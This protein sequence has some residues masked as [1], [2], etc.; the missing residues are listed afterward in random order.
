MNTLDFLALLRRAGAVASPR[1]NRGRVA[2]LWRGVSLADASDRLGQARR[3]D[4]AVTVAQPLRMPG[5]TQRVWTYGDIRRFVAAASAGL[6]QRGVAVGD[7]V[8]VCTSNGLDMPLYCLGVSRAGGVAIP[9]N[10]KLSADELQYILDDSGARACVIDARVHSRVVQPCAER[11]E[12][13]AF[14]LA[15][16]AGSCELTGPSLWDTMS[17]AR[18]IEA[19][20][21]EL[22]AVA[23]IFY[24]SGTTGFPKGAM[25]TG[26]SLLSRFVPLLTRPVFQPETLLCA[27]PM[28]HIMGFVTLLACL[29]AGT[30]I[31]YLSRFH[32]EEVT[33]WL[34]SGEVDA[35]LGVPS[36]YQMLREAGA[37]ERDL[38]GVKVFASAA[39]VMP[40]ELIESFKAAGRLLR[41]PRG[42]GVP[43]M[44]V[45]AYGS[46]ELSGAAMLRV[47]PPFLSPS[48]GGFVGWP[49]PGYSIRI[50]GDDGTELPAGE[51]G[52]LMI[53]GPGVLQG[54]HGRDEATADTIRGG[55]LR[56]GDLA[57]RGRA[58]T[59]KF[60]GRHKDVIK[61]GGYSV[62]PAEIETKLLSHPSIAKAA[63]VGV[64]HPTKGA[65]PVAVVCLEPGGGGEADA[66]CAWIA[67]RV[68]RYK[69]PHRVIVIDESEMPYG[70]TGKI[71]KRRLA[72]RFQNTLAPSP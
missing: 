10:H 50:E 71:L 66:L 11:F 2:A 49:L 34:A 27:L 3:S 72:E 62:F 51:V 18:P 19:H 59:I 70:P 41:L 16:S 65:V 60:V 37:L 57:S 1:R 23:A 13:I 9:L 48:E 53:N 39:D 8:V 24:T 25:L 36:M 61:S 52:E 40:G 6:R 20:Q 5:Y 47:S 31:V 46:V 17:S 22:D 30:H 67:E 4:A 68:A 32:A 29:F 35:F 55:W 33:R 63:V 64:D 58:R 69:A 26:R 42:K 44:F 56:T 45:E 15:D 28:A 21:P 14:H 12:G 7:R 38:T 54:Y 43:A